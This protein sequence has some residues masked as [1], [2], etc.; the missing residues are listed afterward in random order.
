MILST[1]SGCRP[2]GQVVVCCGDHPLTELVLTRCRRVTATSF[3]ETVQTCGYRWANLTNQFRSLAA[4]HSATEQQPN[5]WRIAGLEIR[6]LMPAK[7]GVQKW[8][9]AFAGMTCLEVAV[10]RFIQNA[11]ILAINNTE[12]HCR[13]GVAP[14][15]P[16][17]GFSV[18]HEPRCSGT[19]FRAGT[20]RTC[21]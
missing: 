17:T 11:N 7:A 13:G 8:I 6:V 2:Y 5:Y 20:R 16:W 19:Y 4:G 10:E 1:C 12:S 14:L 18:R 15:C 9:P 21:S 3:G